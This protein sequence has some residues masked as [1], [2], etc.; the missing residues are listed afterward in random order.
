MDL[1][2]R[3]TSM[4]GGM[5]RQSLQLSR[6]QR[7]DPSRASQALALTRKSLAV[8]SRSVN[9]VG[10]FFSRSNKRAVSLTSS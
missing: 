3:K 1:L 5:P 2:T 7:E 8:V 6:C 9:D 10:D 4:R